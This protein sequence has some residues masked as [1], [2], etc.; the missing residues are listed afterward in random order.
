EDLRQVQ[1]GGRAA[2]WL[3]PGPDLLQA[4]G[5]GTWWADLGRKQGGRG[6]HVLLYTPGCPIGSKPSA[7]GSICDSHWYSLTVPPAYWRLP[8]GSDLQLQ[9]LNRGA[10]VWEDLLDAGLDLGDRGVVVGWLVVE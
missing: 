8:P 4:G 10:R 5:G 1:P 6:Q 7:G 3:W 2:R 9:P